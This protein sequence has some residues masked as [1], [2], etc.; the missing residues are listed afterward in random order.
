MSVSIATCLWFDRNA[1]EAVNLYA[2]IFGDNLKIGDVSRYGDDTH[3]PKGTILTIAFELFG[4]HFTAL[5]GGPIYKFSE[6]C[7]IQVTVDNQAEID[8]YWAGLTGNGGEEGPCGWCKDKFGLSWQ[9]APRVLINLLQDPDPSRARRAN[10]A[11]MKMKKLDIATLQ[12][13]AA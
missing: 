13:A 8:R 5:N 7:S 3:M 9:V 12:R 4:Q 10:E 2:S 11:M 1:E 6:A